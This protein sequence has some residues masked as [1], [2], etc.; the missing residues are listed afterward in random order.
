MLSWKHPDLAVR[1]EIIVDDEILELSISGVYL[2]DIP[3]CIT[4]AA[5]P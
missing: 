3:V 2:A 4:H 1:Y 5:S